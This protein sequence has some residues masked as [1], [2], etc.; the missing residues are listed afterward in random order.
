MRILEIAEMWAKHWAMFFDKI[1]SWL[2]TFWSWLMSIFSSNGN[3]EFINA[4]GNLILVVFGVALVIFFISYFFRWNKFV[5][6][7]IKPKAHEGPVWIIVKTI[8][9]VVVFGIIYFLTTKSIPR[10]LTSVSTIQETGSIVDLKYEEYNTDT[11]AAKKTR[12]L[13][14]FP[15]SWVVWDDKLWANAIASNVVLYKQIDLDWTKIAFSTERKTGWGFSTL[16]YK[17]VTSSLTGA[18]QWQL[19]TSN[20]TVY[21][22]KVGDFLRKARE[23]IT[24][25]AWEQKINVTNLWSDI[26]SVIMND[27]PKIKEDKS[28]YNQLVFATEKI[29]QIFKSLKDQHI[30][31]FQDN[32]KNILNTSW[33]E[34]SLSEK[35]FQQLSQRILCVPSKSTSSETP[36]VE[37]NKDNQNAQTQAWATA[38]KPKDWVLVTNN[39][40]LSQVETANR[41]LEATLYLQKFSI[42]SLNE[43]KTKEAK[44]LLL[45]WIIEKNLRTN[46]WFS[47]LVY[48]SAVSSTQ[49]YDFNKAMWILQ[50]DYN[51]LSIPFII[52]FTSWDTILN[53]WICNY[54]VFDNET[55][56]QLKSYWL[57]DFLGYLNEWC[58][59]NFWWVYDYTNNDIDRL[60]KESFSKTIS[61]VEKG[62]LE[63][64]E[65][66][67]KA[68]I[69]YWFYQRANAENKLQDYWF[70]AKWA[71]WEQY[72]STAY[73]QTY[74]NQLDKFGFIAWLLAGIKV[75]FFSFF[76][77]FLPWVIL[78]ALWKVIK[79]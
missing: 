46:S 34:L 54:Y 27:N 52:N 14:E 11:E 13:M 36:K 38:D 64:E 8:V 41:L 45:G 20:G 15:L 40:F 6:D 31:L 72:I 66:G 22:M 50:T 44:F 12:N 37:E 51:A 30:I 74:H 57:G 68:Y 39:A 77:Y 7:Y 10:I 16:P 65:T 58:S 49:S 35:V 33:T 26:Y 69:N 48:N 47:W 67:N 56:R 60:G 78:I 32:L 43:V 55:E 24:C 17:V 62:N 59:K 9:F 23:H 75:F 19:I 5:Q 53:Y 18:D 70:V 3:Y 42:P 76:L 25:N 29:S 63:W 2:K 21:F 28:K 79:S 73:T 4:F 71:G 1:L 61:L